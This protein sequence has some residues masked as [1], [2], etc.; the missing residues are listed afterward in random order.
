MF[1]AFVACFHP[2]HNFFLAVT[3]GDLPVLKSLQKIGT[4]ECVCEYS[5]TIGFFCFVLNVFFFLS[6][7][8]LDLY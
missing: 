4:R 3:S 1:V 2:L 8:K 5:V 7:K 6:F